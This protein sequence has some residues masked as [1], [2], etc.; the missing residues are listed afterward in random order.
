MEDLDLTALDAA[1]APDTMFVRF[2]RT[3]PSFGYFVGQVGEVLE[4]VGHD[5]I[6]DGF[7]EAAEKPEPVA[8][9]AVETPAVEAAE[10]ANETAAVAPDPVTLVPAA[11][12]SAPLTDEIR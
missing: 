6:A 2:L 7:A 10:P 4:K 3:H 11:E 8:E 5:L 1:P 9:E 12:V